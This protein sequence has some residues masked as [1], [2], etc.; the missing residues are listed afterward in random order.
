MQWLIPLP[1]TTMLAIGAA[2]VAAVGLN[3]SVRIVIMA[4]FKEPINCSGHV[5]GNIIDQFGKFHSNPLRGEVGNSTQYSKSLGEQ[6]L[7]DSN[8]GPKT[9][10]RMK[11]KAQK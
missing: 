6:R 8:P 5:N 2:Q 4:E 9:W 11:W 3:A 10:E 7:G 1:I